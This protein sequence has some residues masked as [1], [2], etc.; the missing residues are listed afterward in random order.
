M[1]ADALSR[2]PVFQ[3][4]EDEDEAIDTAIQC[5]RVRETNKL[6]DIEEAIL[7]LQCHRASDQN[8]R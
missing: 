4:E 1:I 8:R 3:P 5:L 6:A 2:A 7:E